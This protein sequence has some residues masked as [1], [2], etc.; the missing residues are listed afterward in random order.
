MSVCLAPWAGGHFFGLAVFFLWIL[1]WGLRH[2]F[3][4]SLSLFSPPQASI[5]AKRRRESGWWLA[6]WLTGWLATKMT[7]DKNISSLKAC[8]SE[9]GEK[10]YV[11]P[12]HSDGNIKE[13]E[14]EKKKIEDSF[15]LAIQTFACLPACLPVCLPACLY[16]HRMSYYR[17]PSFS[18]CPAL[19]VSLAEQKTGHRFFNK[20]K[21]SW[22][23]L[24]RKRN[25][26]HY[27]RRWFLN[28]TDGLV[29]FF[30]ES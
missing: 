18:F 9:E 30:H 19:R 2:F 10:K 14:R 25:L 29:S 7:A 21:C 28:S 22:K 12:L 4:L 15:S 11:C 20:K 13:E 23:S 1:D 17:G 5:I 16:S 26:F 6:D 24:R 8:L 3:L 27:I